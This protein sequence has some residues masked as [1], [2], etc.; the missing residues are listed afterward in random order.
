LVG[1]QGRAHGKVIQRDDRDWIKSRTLLLSRTSTP[2]AEFRRRTIRETAMATKRT[3][4]AL[5]VALA[6]M[7]LPLAGTALAASDGGSSADGASTP[8]CDTGEVWNTRTQECEAKSSSRMD[9]K[10]LYTEGRN[11][12]LAGRYHQ[13]L[14]TLDAVRHPDSMT[15]T[16]IGYSW[17][18]LGDFGRAQAFYGKALALDPN[19]V[20]T[21]EYLGEAYVE[22]GRLALAK[23]ELTAVARI[24]GTASEQYGDLSRAIDGIPDRS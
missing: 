11:L 13:A 7:S 8:S 18:K 16:M 4:L 3:F 9:D 19:N 21:H 14:T 22:Q 12:A 23:A 1:R 5:T 24:S 17:R 15:F 6:S 20:N 2:E 10:S